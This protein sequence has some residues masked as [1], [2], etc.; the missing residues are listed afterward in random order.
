M[1]LG[2]GRLS[3]RLVAAGVA[4]RRRHESPEMLEEDLAFAENF[5]PFS[6]TDLN[7]LIA[8]APE[9]RQYICRQCHQCRMASGLHLSP[10]I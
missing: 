5:T 6:D 9:Y 10:Y 3:L 8:T 7:Q 4:G 1:A 2:W